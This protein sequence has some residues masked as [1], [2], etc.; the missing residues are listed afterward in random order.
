MAQNDFSDAWSPSSLEGLH[1]D[2]VAGAVV[3]ERGEMVSN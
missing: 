2:S 3:T 1:L